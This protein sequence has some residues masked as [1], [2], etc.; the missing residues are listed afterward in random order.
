M[1]LDYKISEGSLFIQLKDSIYIVSIENIRD[2]KIVNPYEN[3]TWEEVVISEIK[4]PI[5]EL[6]LNE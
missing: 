2:N 4:I 1:K 5:K 6:I 3:Y